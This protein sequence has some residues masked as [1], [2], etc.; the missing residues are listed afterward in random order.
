[1]ILIV[2]KYC[3]YFLA[4][5]TTI[6]DS[7][8]PDSVVVNTTE[9]GTFSKNENKAVFTKSISSI[10]GDLQLLRCYTSSR[11][12][13]RRTDDFSNPFS[14]NVTH[15]DIFFESFF[16]KVFKSESATRVYA[17]VFTLNSIKLLNG[18]KLNLY[19]LNLF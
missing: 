12:S 11:R 13:I 1:M 4:T 8:V 16:E 17:C 3:L 18:C 15:V 5:F 6:T 19:R 7:K 9:T 14:S 2:I 10:T